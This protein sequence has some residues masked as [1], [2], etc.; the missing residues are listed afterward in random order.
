VEEVKEKVNG[1]TGSGGGGEKKDYLEEKTARSNIG[2][3]EEVGEDS[4]KKKKTEV[5]NQ[6]G[7]FC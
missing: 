1:G 2:Q 4:W 3:R 6:R 7:S 5:K